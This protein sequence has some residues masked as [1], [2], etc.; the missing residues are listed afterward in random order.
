MTAAFMTIAGL[1]IIAATICEVFSDLFR[2]GRSGALS[3]WIGRRLFQLLRRWRRATPLAGPTTILLV[4]AA[5]VLL[6]VV[7]FALVYSPLYPLDFRT[8]IGEVPP[9]TA[10]F[11]TVF[12]FSFET[13]ITLGYGDLVPQSTVSRMHHVQ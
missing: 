2:P 10:R 12:Y 8:S 11:V 3:D 4:I 6:L 13:L 5:W 9:H 1:A 7:G